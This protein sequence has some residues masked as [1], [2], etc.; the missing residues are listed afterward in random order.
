MV[1]KIKVNK[2]GL[3]ASAA[4][5]DL[6]LIAVS[7]MSI[8]PAIEND[9]AEVATIFGTIMATGFATVSAI[10]AVVAFLDR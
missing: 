3:I 10:I 8:L 2:T 6:A 9:A 4:S 1:M 5:A 7:L